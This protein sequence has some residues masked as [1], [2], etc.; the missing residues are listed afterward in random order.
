MTTSVTP[1][2]LDAFAD[3]SG[4]LDDIVTSG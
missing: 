1:K 4:A 3:S 2:P